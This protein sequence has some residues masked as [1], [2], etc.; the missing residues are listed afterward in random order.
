LIVTTETLSCKLDR[1]DLATAPLFG[2]AATA[3]V[4]YG[5]AHLKQMNARLVC[6][7]LSAQGDNG[8]MLSVPLQNETCITMDGHKVFPVAVRKMILMLKRAC[9]QAGLCVD[10]LDLIVPHQANQRI[11]AAVRRRINLPEEKVFSNI[12]RIGNTSSS[13]IPLCLEKVFQ[14]HHSGKRVGLCA[15]GGGLT[16]G[17]AVLQIL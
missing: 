11:I 12:R 8:E 16:F 13:S 9:Y 3:S 2:D 15:F 17:G 5:E 1:K 6:L 10:D 7:A 4:V 14:Q